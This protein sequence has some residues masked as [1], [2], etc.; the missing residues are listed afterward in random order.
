M[1]QAP[2]AGSTPR[3]FDSKACALTH[4]VRT[5]EEAKGGGLRSDQSL[6]VSLP[7]LPIPD[8]CDTFGWARQASRIA[9]QIIYGSIA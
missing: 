3:K 1:E 4:P 6:I 8:T 7:R 2:T 5:S 9:L